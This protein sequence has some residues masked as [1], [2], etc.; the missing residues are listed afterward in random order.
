MATRNNTSVLIRGA[1][2]IAFLLYLPFWF[3]K[4]FQPEPKPDEFKLGEDVAVV[5]QE[6]AFGARDSPKV[7]RST[8]DVMEKPEEPSVDEQ[9][10]DPDQLDTEQLDTDQLDA[11]QLDT[12]QLDTGQLDTGQLDSGQDAAETGKNDGSG[13]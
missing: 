9:V 10:R 1:V 12:G 3:N 13:L 8:D 11:G 6:A 4:R 2:A 7:E 5:D